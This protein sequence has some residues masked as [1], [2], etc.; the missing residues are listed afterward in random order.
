MKEQNCHQFC[1]WVRNTQNLDHYVCL[2]CG[3]ERF[4][5]QYKREN[6]PV[7]VLVLMAIA[8][9]LT[10]LIQEGKQPTQ[11]TPQ[12]ESLSTP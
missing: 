2:K 8:I 5:N 6:P 12:L 4:L 7:G 10:L 1:H 11:A 9:L 3:Q